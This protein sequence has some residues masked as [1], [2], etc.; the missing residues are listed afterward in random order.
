MLVH[1][2]C[3]Y[4]TSSK[5]GCFM[6]KKQLYASLEITE[7]EIRLLVGEF[8]MSRFNVLRVEKMSCKGIHNKKIVK[9]QLVS[10]TIIKLIK[11]AEEALSLKIRSVILCLPSVD[12]TCAKKR[13]NVAIEEGS[14]KIL[15]SHIRLGLEKAVN[16]EK[17]DDSVFVNVGSIKY[18][19]GG[20]SSRTM[21]L[22]ERADML[23][24][25]VDLLYANK[26]SVYSHAMCVEKA[27]INI[28]DICLDTYAISEESA[29]IENSMDK[30][31][32]L[33]DLQ[34]SDTTLSLFYKGRLLECDHLG[35]GYERFVQ[36]VKRRT[37]LSE[38]ECTRLVL[39]NCFTDNGLYDDG[40]CYIWLDREDH[41][42][43][44]KKDLYEIVKDDVAYW[45][46]KINTL[47]EP[48]HTESACKVV[49]SGKGADIVGIQ[50]VLKG[51]TFP[52]EM[53]VPTTIGARQGSY[54][55]LLGSLYCTKKWQS[56]VGREEVSIEYNNL[57]AR[58][59]RR[60]D[61]NAFTKKLKNILLINNK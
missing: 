15:K 24:M 42:Q 26:E 46:T 22:D 4:S 17:T 53:Y 32:V 51:I 56:I 33:V 49:L 30:Y 25:D 27:G 10:A 5:G 40:I 38:E 19:I 44:T 7:E 8:F 13:V 43:L 34:K 58:E 59:Q 39:E 61:E 14:R 35:F 21:P 3:Y 60:E 6:A 41:K 2:L 48:L 47:C 29:V 16:S 50:S 55:A 37:R 20:I 12:V 1:N 36:S 52:V 54:C 11:N 28:L 57:V 45:T 18:I 31:I 9:P 23:T